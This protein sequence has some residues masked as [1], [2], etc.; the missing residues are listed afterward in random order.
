MLI[1]S[2]IKP[3]HVHLARQITHA[4]SVRGV[5]ILASQD[6]TYDSVLIDTLYDH[7][8][9]EARKAITERYAGK[10]GKAM[11]LSCTGIDECLEI[12]GRHSDPRR[13]H[14]A[15]LRHKFGSHGTPEMLGDWEWWENGIHRPV[16]ERERM[17]D[18]FRFFPKHIY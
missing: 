17:R 13:C 7:M 2:I 5:L 12:I 9:E 15:T 14:R 16:D 18:L 6:F 3:T 1:C 4:L 10:L 8:D 11:L